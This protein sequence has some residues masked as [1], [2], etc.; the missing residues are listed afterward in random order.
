MSLAPAPLHHRGLVPVEEWRSPVRLILRRA[1]QTVEIQ[2]PLE[3][4]DPLERGAYPSALDWV[5]GESNPE[6]EAAEYLEARYL[7]HIRATSGYWHMPFQA[8]RRVR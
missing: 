4:R 6:A 7:N 5:R 2:N 3:A 8:L 1:G